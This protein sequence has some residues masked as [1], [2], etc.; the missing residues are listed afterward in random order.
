MSVFAADYIRP[1][2]AD[3]VA[4]V[5]TNSEAEPWATADGTAEDYPE[6]NPNSEPKT[7]S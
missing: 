4:E 3:E 1:A 6:W 2:T 7:T 5:H